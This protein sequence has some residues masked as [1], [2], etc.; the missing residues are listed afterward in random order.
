MPRKQISLKPSKPKGL[1]DMPAD[2]ET[3]E[4]WLEFLNWLEEEADL[5]AEREDYYHLAYSNY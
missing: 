4:Q 2:F 1:S 5:A 3:L